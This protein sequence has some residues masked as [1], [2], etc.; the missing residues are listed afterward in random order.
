[1]S[2]LAR[3]Q[4][5]PWWPGVC[6]RGSRYQILAVTCSL[7][8]EVLF[9][10]S[11]KQLLM[12]ERKEADENNLAGVNIDALHAETLLCP[13]YKVRSSEWGSSERKMPGCDIDATITWLELCL[14]CTPS[15]GASPE[16]TLHHD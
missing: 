2:L 12:L 6:A 8:G 13:L 9:G 15:A 4:A 1:M 7:A 14:A 11:E 3:K 16:M 5:S 10:L